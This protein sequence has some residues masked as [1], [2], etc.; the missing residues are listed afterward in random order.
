[1]TRIHV[2][3]D[4]GDLDRIVSGRVA[5]APGRSIRL[6]L[7]G[8]SPEE[9]ARWQ[10]RLGRAYGACGCTTSAA[11]ATV[12]LLGYPALALTAPVLRERGLPARIMLGVAIVVGAALAGKVIGL[13]VGRIWLRCSV[14]AF[15]RHLARREAAP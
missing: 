3:R 8:L 5:L 9:R 12:A 10:H 14:T 7:A 6:E 4:G 2:V 1:M 13:A 11:F 15:R